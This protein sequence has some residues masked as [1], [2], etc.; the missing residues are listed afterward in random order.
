MNTKSIFCLLLAVAV[1]A[2]SGLGC[3]HTAQGFGKDVE[4]VGEKIQDKT[5]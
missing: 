5:Q 3:R 1:L 4:K 2:L